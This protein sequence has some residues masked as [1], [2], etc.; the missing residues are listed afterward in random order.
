MRMMGMSVIQKLQNDREVHSVC[1]KDDSSM[2]G[3]V[4]IKHRHI[5][6]NVQYTCRNVNVVNLKNSVDNESIE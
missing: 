6:S 2:S 1:I 5:Q 3:Q 4:G